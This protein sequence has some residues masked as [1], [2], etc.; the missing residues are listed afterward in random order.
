MNALPLHNLLSNTKK[1]L[2]IRV[3]EF[4]FVCLENALDDEIMASL[5]AES[6]M[7]QSSARKAKENDPISYQASLADIGD[8]ALSLL[9]SPF[10]YQILQMISDE[11]LALT[12]EASCYTYYGPGDFLSAHRDRFPECAVTVIVY[13]DA[14]SPNPSSPQTGLSLRIF[15]E[16]GADINA[17]R[18]VIP[19]QVGSL[20]IGH[21]SRVFH[22]RPTLQK[23]EYVIALTACFR[24]L[25]EANY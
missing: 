20:V 7:K 19:T 2:S 6:N 8:T 12:A 16:Q 9:R 25:T 17:L 5:L 15:D 14:T 18:I 24:A 23:G 4:G 22:E 3:Q 1:Y 13:I 11:P 21:G 10:I